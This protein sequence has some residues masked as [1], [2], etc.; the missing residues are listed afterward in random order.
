MQHWKRNDDGSEEVEKLDVD[1]RVAGLEEF[2]DRKREGGGGGFVPPDDEHG[3]GVEIDPHWS[4]L[5]LPNHP[6]GEGW[7]QPDPDKPLWP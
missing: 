2:K 4:N 6:R 7:I 3:E 1:P 5:K